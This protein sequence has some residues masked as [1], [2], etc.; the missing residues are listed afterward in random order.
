MTSECKMV[1]SKAGHMRRSL[2]YDLG[3][4]L[5]IDCYADECYR[6]RIQNGQLKQ[7]TYVQY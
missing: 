2:A 3:I 5:E 7:S 4:E 1:R 6:R